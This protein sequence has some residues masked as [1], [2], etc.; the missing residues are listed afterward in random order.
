MIIFLLITNLFAATVDL[1]KVDQYLHKSTLTKD[2][3][4]NQNIVDERMS[5]VVGHCD[6]LQDNISVT[7][8]DDASVEI[9]SFNAQHEP[10][11]IKSISADDW[12]NYKGNLI[13]FEIVNL[14]SYGYEVQVDKIEDDSFEVNVNDQKQVIT[15]IRVYITAN[16]SAGGTLS[17]EITVTNQLLGIGQIIRKKWSN[18]LMGSTLDM[19][20]LLIFKN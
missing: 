15:G 19:M 9:T 14:N 12:Q 11:N 18:T 16:S 17:K 3:S 4:L 13:R 8:V 5:C 10:I 6:S 1:E 2:F 7:K 20:N